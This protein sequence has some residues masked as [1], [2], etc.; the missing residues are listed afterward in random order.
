VFCFALLA[1]AAITFGV[2]AAV[3]ETRPPAQGSRHGTS[4]LLDYFR[5]FGHL[6]FTA[7]VLQTGLST[8]TFITVASAAPTLMKE[9]LHRSATEF[10]LYFLLFPIGFFLGNLLTARVGNRGATDTM[11][12][13]GSLLSIAAVAVQSSLLLAGYFNPLVIFLPGSFITMAQ[14]IALPYGQAG[15]MATI[16]QLSGTAAGVGVFVQLFCGAVFTQIYG[17]L[18]TG[19]PGPMMAT[20]ALSACL[21][22]IA[23]SVP[24]LLR[25]RGR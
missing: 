4:V 20:T 6:R 21:C 18:A 24:F 8:A 22:L 15:A 10:G 17:L 1:G 11:V 25:M 9:Q 5:L 23:G 16:P 3:P 19:T 2:Y 13:L 7:Y 12:L 14:G